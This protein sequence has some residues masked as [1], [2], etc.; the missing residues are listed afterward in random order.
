MQL[1]DM[2]E[3]RAIDGIWKILK[4]KQAYDDCVY[5]KMGDLYQLYTVDFIGEGVHFMR[6]WN[7]EKVGAFFASINLSDIAAM[8]GLPDL[9]MASMSFPQDL[10]WDY[11]ESFV[12]GMNSILQGFGVPYYGG[13]FKESKSVGM[14]GFAVGH[15]E[16]NR[17]LRRNTVSKGER[18]FVT[19]ELGKQAAGYFLW[20]NGHDE[21]I[22]YLLD[23][24][25]RIE[26]GRR[27]SELGSACM[28]LSDGLLA[29]VKFMGNEKYGLGI[30]FDKIPIHKLAYEV[31]EDYGL[32]L[33]YLAT[34]FG[35]EYEL[36]YT[37]K[38]G[39]VGTEIGEVVER[40][41]AGIWKENKKIEGE[42]YAH[43]SQT[44][45]K[46]GRQ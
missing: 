29:S 23:V 27:I 16:A 38:R 9:F 35:G 34:M 3:R 37:A 17:I 8:G 46:I 21:G 6:E 43:F 32:P 2:G 26:E 36:I 10:D 42:G 7:P 19:G 15:V 5:I 12:L 13:D 44:L 45:G 24:H 28:D 22:E 1:K 30:Y 39:V 20:K 41:N 33:E 14:S 40:E 11:V 18:V 4:K 31:S 25:P